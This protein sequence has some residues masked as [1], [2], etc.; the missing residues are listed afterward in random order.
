MKNMLLAVASAAHPRM[1]IFANPCMGSFIVR[2]VSTIRNQLDVIAFRQ[3][4]ASPG[5]L[6]PE[7]PVNFND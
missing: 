4:P 3:T 5:F 7:T 6:S 1:F 2:C